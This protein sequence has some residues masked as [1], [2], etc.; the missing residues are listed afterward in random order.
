MALLTVKVADP[1]PRCYIMLGLTDIS[2]SMCGVNVIT[3]HT[4]NTEVEDEAV[5]QPEDVY[6]MPEL[7]NHNSLIHQNTKIAFLQKRHQILC[8]M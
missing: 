4:N 7:K 3:E 1:W 8:S 5:T 2:R 6:D